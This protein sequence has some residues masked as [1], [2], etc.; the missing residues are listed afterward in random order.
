MSA[1]VTAWVPVTRPYVSVETFLNVPVPESVTVARLMSVLEATPS[2][3][4]TTILPTV[5]AK[6]RLT[7]VSVP[8]RVE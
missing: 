1:V 7:Q 5:P 3:F 8:V 2:P 4:V 6:V